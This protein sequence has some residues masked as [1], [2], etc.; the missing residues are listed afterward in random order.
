MVDNLTPEEKLLRLIRGKAK[1]PAAGSHPQKTQQ[2]IRAHI[3]PKSAI[4]LK[5][6]LGLSKIFTFNKISIILSILIILAAGYSIFELLIPQPSFNLEE[7]ARSKREDGIDRESIQI[8]PSKPYSHYSQQ[9]NTRDIFNA[10]FLSS[11][12][13]DTSMDSSLERKIAH[14]S[15]V[16]IVLDEVPQVIIEDKKNHKTHFL[17]KGD[18]I[19]EIKIE[20]ISESKVILSYEDEEFEMAP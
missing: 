12:I 13:A 9:I 1:K 2:K 14:L 19:G 16:G 18:Y 7:Y 10:P 11:R 8:S 3:D 5:K 20:D 6:S 17:N 4:I 15:L